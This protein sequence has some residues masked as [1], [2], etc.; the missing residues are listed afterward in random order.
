MVRNEIKELIKTAIKKLQNE[1]VFPGFEIPE[2]EVEHPENKVF[3]DYSTN[4]ALAI[5]RT[6]AEGLDT[7]VNELIWAAGK[8]PYHRSPK[9]VGEEIKKIIESDNNLIIKK[10]EI[11]GPGFINFFVSEEYLQNQ[12]EEILKQKNDYGKL[13]IGKKEKINVEFISANPTGPL[14]LGNGRGG[15]CGDVLANVLEKAGYK[16]ERE[17]YINDAGEQVRKL[18]HSVLG[19]SEAVYQG[20]YVKN[21]KIRLT[22]SIKLADSSVESQ[23]EKAAKIILDEMIKPS[24]KKM[25]IEFDNWFFEQSLYDKK[26][27][28]KALEF[29]KEK[30]LTYEQEGALWFKSTQFGDDKDRVL[31]KADGE[32]TYLASDV[33]YLENKFKRG[34]GKLIFY[35][36]ADHYGYI[37]RIKAAAV[38]LGYKKE[39]VEIIIMQLVRLIQGGQEVKMSK[40]SGIYVTIDELIDEVGLDA[41][42]FFFLMRGADSHL[43]FD[44]DLAKE[45]SDKNPVYYVQYAHARIC[46][47]LDKALKLKVKKENEKTEKDQAESDLAKKLINFPEIIED[48]AKDYQ[49]QRI[50]QYAT[51]LATAFHHFYQVSRVISEDGIVDKKRLE[52]VSATKIILENTLK[53]MGISAPEKM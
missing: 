25:G 24:V 18:G 49:L 38:A 43:N 33:A 5:Y 47:I 40:R 10:I 41:T 7:H 48:T 37:N 13:E 22:D 4:I 46:S 51:D 52:L 15:F 28:D 26:E 44:M 19:D 36:G 16:V 8:N 35:W 14:T 27:V 45:Q 11:A 30:G 32:K 42:R 21:I 3:G 39:Q 23:G 29:L 9:D 34:F 31:I 53:L 20:Q 2:I 50:P 1:G 12:V 6:L 17:Y